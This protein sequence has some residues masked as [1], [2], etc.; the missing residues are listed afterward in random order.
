MIRAKF[1]V[2]TTFCSL[3]KAKVKV[4]LQTWLYGGFN[5]FGASYCEKKVGYTLTHF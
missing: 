3:H 5:P 2:N 1:S 4:G